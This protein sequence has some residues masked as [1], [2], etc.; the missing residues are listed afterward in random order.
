MGISQLGKILEKSETEEE[1]EEDSQTCTE[2]DVRSSRENHTRYQKT[3]SIHVITN[4][5]QK[6]LPMQVGGM[7]VYRP[8]PA[9]TAQWKDIT[10]ASGGTG[11]MY[12]TAVFTLL[13]A[14]QG[15]TTA[16][17]RYGNNVR[18]LSVDLQLDMSAVVGTA[19][20][21]F[22]R[23]MV[24]YD[25]QPNNAI[26]S[27]TD[28]LVAGTSYAFR[29]MDKLERFVV[30][31]DVQKSL[32]PAG[33]FEPSWIKK[34][35]D[36]HGLLTRFSISPGTSVIA[37]ISIGSLYLVTI[38]AVGSAATGHNIDGRCRVRFLNTA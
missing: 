10:I 20:A 32:Q 26:F 15:G 22:G 12:Q 6:K 3:H 34:K 5:I 11:N 19:L 30:L 14:I 35:V 24:V 33:V 7:R 13:S 4:K 29:N 1:E 17:D 28:L 2:T 18:L 23:V 25:R 38:G 16:S 27:I 36:C 9:A 8:G 37:D 21:N 31:M